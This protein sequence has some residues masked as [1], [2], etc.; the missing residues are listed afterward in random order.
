M[1]MRIAVSKPSKPIKAIAAI[2]HMF[3]L[4]GGFRDAVTQ[5]PMHTVLFA[6]LFEAT[7]VQF[8][9]ASLGVLASPQADIASI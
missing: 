1:Q 8:P 5:S 4:P 9:L 3:V 7:V 6:V 2:I